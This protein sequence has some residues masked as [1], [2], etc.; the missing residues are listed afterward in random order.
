MVCNG[1]F[2]NGWTDLTALGNALATCTG[3][4]GVNA[5]TCS[6]NVNGQGPGSSSNQV[7]EVP[8]IYEEDVGLNGTVSRGS[9][10]S[11]QLSTVSILLF[12]DA[13]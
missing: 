5:A 4:Q 2:I 13:T 11:F 9:D 7:P 3:P 8:A 1:D 12:R 10:E 6:L